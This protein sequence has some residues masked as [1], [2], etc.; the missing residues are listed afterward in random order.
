MRL[1]AIQSAQ[2][3]DRR[4]YF[5]RHILCSTVVSLNWKYIAFNLCLYLSCM[6]LL[7]YFNLNTIWWLFTGYI[8][9]D[10]KYWKIKISSRWIHGLESSFALFALFSLRL[11]SGSGPTSD[12]GWN[13][14]WHIDSVSAQV[15][16]LG[17]GFTITV[18]SLILL[19]YAIII[20][21]LSSWNFMQFYI[22]NLSTF[23]SHLKEEPMYLPIALLFHLHKIWKLFDPKF[24]AFG[25]LL[26][27]FEELL[28]RKCIK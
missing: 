20:N 13:K 23:D 17:I 2:L 16:E 28:F 9:K 12:L 15:W 3:L 4:H 10:T 1:E 6:S 25:F 8:W 14:R 26:L 19:S 22:D 11:G 21:Y 24:I 27:F 5:L 7:V 18:Q